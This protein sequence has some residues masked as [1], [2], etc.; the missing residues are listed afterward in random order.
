MRLSEQEYATLLARGHVRAGGEPREP[1]G[2]DASSEQRF[3]AQVLALAKQHGWLAYHVRDSRGSTAGFPDLCLVRG[4][5]PLVM[6]ELKSTQ[7]KLTMEQLQ[8]LS[9]LAQA[10][11]IESGLVRPTDWQTIVQ[12]L[13]APRAQERP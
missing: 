7:G 4:G 3:M 10:S 5:S 8:W 12:I 1:P 9:L 2:R 13:T 6:W 11:R